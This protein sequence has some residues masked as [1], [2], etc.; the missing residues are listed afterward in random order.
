MSIY[1]IEPRREPSL[2]VCFT[3]KLHIWVGFVNKNKD[4]FLFYLLQNMRLQYVHILFVIKDINKLN[5]NLFLLFTNFPI[6]CIINYTN[7]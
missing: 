3:T 2:F 4:M 6:Y 5:K 7:F 1:E